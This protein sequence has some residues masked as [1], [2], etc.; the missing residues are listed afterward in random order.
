MT[1]R[2]LLAASGALAMTAAAGAAAAEPTA[3]ARYTAVALQLRCDAV[4]QDAT[5][6]AAR[7]RMA[8]AT[9]RMGAMVAGVAGFQRGFN[10]VDV[11]LVVLPEYWM[12]SFPFGE[13]R[14]RATPSPRSPSATG[15]FCVR[16]TTRM[17]RSSRTSISRRTWS[18]ARTAMWCCA[19]GA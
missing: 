9:T 6:E 1:R 2:K 15:S 12:T 7:A 8:A 11:K 5:R 10:G 16:T 17:I 19:T 4:N 18:M 14:R 3:P 13:T